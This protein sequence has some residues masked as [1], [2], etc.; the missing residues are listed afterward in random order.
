MLHGLVTLPHFF[1]RLF[2]ILFDKFRLAMDNELGLGTRGGLLCIGGRYRL[3]LHFIVDV[4]FSL[5]FG[6][7][8]DLA[9]GYDAVQP[10][11]AMSGCASKLQAGILKNRGFSFFF[12]REH[13]RNQECITDFSVTLS[14]VEK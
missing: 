1:V 11:V 3:S 4:L 12:S 10:S 7:R 14:H 2:F 5:L 13:E 8:V 6:V 9:C